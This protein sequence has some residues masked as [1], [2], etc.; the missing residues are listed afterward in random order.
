MNNWGDWW[1]SEVNFRLLA[2][3]A[4][5]CGSII[6]RLAEEHPQMRIFSFGQSP[7][8]VTKT[9]EMI[10]KT[11]EK[12][13][14]DKPSTQNWTSGR[15]PFSGKAGM[16]KK[17][18]GRSA[19]THASFK[20]TRNIVTKTQETG[21][22]TFLEELGFSP[23]KIVEQGKEGSKTFVVERMNFGESLASF[24]CTLFSWT[25]EQ[26]INPEVLKENLHFHTLIGSKAP[27]I[28]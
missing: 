1:E 16:E 25:E 8:W 4:E 13:A 23:K 6:K 7:A 27:S 28:L 2:N 26:G 11:T 17:D 9:L 14:S 3:L 10:V 12:M 5:E 19:L 18:D 21:Y 24:A 22:K 15:I 20:R